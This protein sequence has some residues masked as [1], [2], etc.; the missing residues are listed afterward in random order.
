MKRY[1]PGRLHPQEHLSGGL[2]GCGSDGVEVVGSLRVIA[3]EAGQIQ[4]LLRIVCG[5]V[6]CCNP[7]FLHT[8]HY[9][10]APDPSTLPDEPITTKISK[11]VRQEAQETRS[12]QWAFLKT[13]TVAFREDWPRRDVDTCS[14]ASLIHLGGE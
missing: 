9:P 14:D 11:N 13:A 7:S 10:S 4:Y 1:S 8:P 2:L 5:V 3:D 12:D 6:F